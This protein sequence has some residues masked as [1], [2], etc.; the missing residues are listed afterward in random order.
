MAHK[1]NSAARH[2]RSRPRTEIPLAVRKLVAGEHV[3]RAYHR[4]AS[5]ATQ[6][7]FRQKACGIGPAITRFIALTEGNI[8]NRK[9]DWRPACM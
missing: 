8:R 7:N 5:A 6:E 2:V 9:K 3:I 1:N 4:A